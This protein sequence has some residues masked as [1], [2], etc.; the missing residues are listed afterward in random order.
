[1][2]GSEPDGSDTWFYSG[3]VRLV[4]VLVHVD[5][6]VVH[7]QTVADDAGVTRVTQA[8]VR[9]ADESP[10]SHRP[11]HRTNIPSR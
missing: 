11:Q 8:G 3:C 1:V 4:R 2:S 9:Q 10:T 6:L 7:V 5:R